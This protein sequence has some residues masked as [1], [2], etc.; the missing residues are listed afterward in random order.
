[1]ELNTE[2]NSYI[3]KAIKESVIH[4][5]KLEGLINEQEFRLLV[6]KIK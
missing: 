4:Q 1:M 5:L 2:A 6:N 3:S